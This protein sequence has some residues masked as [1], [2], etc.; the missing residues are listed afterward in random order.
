MSASA[1]TILQFGA[2]RF[3]RAF[4]DRFVQHANDALISGSDVGF[5]SAGGGEETAG[6]Y[7]CNRDVR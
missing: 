3:L 1:E 6:G 4:V 5:A 7:R 2:G